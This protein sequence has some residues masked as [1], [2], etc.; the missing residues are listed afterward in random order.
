[1]WSGLY[2][3]TGMQSEIPIITCMEGLLLW[4][5]EKSQQIYQNMRKTM[6]II[7]NYYVTMQ[8]AFFLAV[9]VNVI[10]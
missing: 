9:N 5:P 10:H 3:Q 6:N 4:E 7:L 8:L 2:W 1:M